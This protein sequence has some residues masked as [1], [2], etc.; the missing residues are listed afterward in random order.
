MNAENNIR[1]EGTPDDS[2]HQGDKTRIWRN[3]KSN[4]SG[5]DPTSLG[6]SSD[7]HGFTAQQQD[8]SIEGEVEE[9]TE[10]QN[11]NESQKTLR[12]DIMHIHKQPGLSLDEKNKKIQQLRNKI[13]AKAKARASK[14]S[15]NGAVNIERSFHAKHS[16]ICV[17]GKAR[18]NGVRAEA[19][20]TC[21]GSANVRTAKNKASADRRRTSPSSSSGVESSEHAVS[22]NST[23]GPSS[24]AGLEV[25]QPGS[26]CCNHD[27]E[28][29]CSGHSTSHEHDGR[30]M[31][32]E[33]DECSECRMQFERE[34]LEDV[35]EA[36]VAE[37]IS[38]LMGKFPGADGAFRCTHYERSCWLKAD[39]CGK[40]YPC[41]RCHDHHEDHLIDRHATKFV[42]CTICGAE[43]VKVGRNCSECGVQFARYF[44]EICKF[45]DDE[46]G[47]DIYHCP[48]CGICRIGKGITGPEPDNYHCDKC[49]SCVPI[50]VKDTHP[51]M[52]QSL[53]SNCPVC[54]EYLATSTAQVVFMRCGHAMHHNCFE[55]YTMSSYTC[56]ICFKSLTDMTR[57]YEALTKRISAEILPDEYKRKKTEVLCNDC[58]EQSVVKWHFVFH[59]CGNPTCGGYNTRVL[60]YPNEEQAAVLEAKY[61]KGKIGD[62]DSGDEPTGVSR[63]RQVFDGIETVEVEQLSYKEA[64]EANLRMLARM[65]DENSG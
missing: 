3:E 59:Q 5:G 54:N 40:Y 48:K 61:C 24:S 19:R 10:A 45:H 57:W 49:N 32:D 2:P 6:A 50:Q 39:C 27:D 47:K 26:S 9:K 4:L 64:Y 51:C 37:R 60:S 8:A 15:K 18:P 41:R 22:G 53:E 46:E 13:A 7:H 30:S 21:G 42:G 36:A 20:R 23:S 1:V 38:A 29:H 35:S 11:N 44:C 62:S 43:D 16:R 52:N 31:S 56:P 58:G 28:T 25:G 55:Q 33:E 65:R 14:G 63:G 17:H 12:R 34:R